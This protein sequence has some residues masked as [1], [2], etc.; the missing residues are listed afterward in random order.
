[1]GFFVREFKSVSGES[2]AVLV[3]DQGSPFFWSNV[4]AVSDYRN[5]G[6]SPRTISKLL[7]TLAM[8][9]TWADSYGI[10]FD[11]ALSVGELITM[12]QAESLAQ[13]LRLNA[14]NQEIAVSK[15][16]YSFARNKVITLERQQG[17]RKTE[18]SEVVA[19][20]AFEAATRIRWVIKYIEWQMDRRLGSLDR[21]GK[22]SSLIKSVGAIVVSRL[23]ALTPRAKQTSVDEE[24]LEGISKEECVIAEELFRPRSE[25]NPFTPGFHQERNYL[26]W[27][28]LY[29]TGMR[30]EEL[31]A[32]LVEKVDYSLRRVQITKSKT[33]KRTVPISELLAL[34][35]HDFILNHWSKISPRLRKHGFLFTTEKGDHLGLNSINLIFRT[36]RRNNDDLPDFLAPHVMRRTW[37]DRFLELDDI[38]QEQSGNFVG[39]QAIQNRLQG[40]GDN[41]K[42]RERYGKGVIRKK[43]DKIAEK[44][45]NEL[46]EKKNDQE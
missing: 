20:S 22:D 44:L 15:T 21:A 30:R 11:K 9:H 27:R 1:M 4:F 10:D 12:E 18:G 45:A 14:E 35:F 25:S 36:A 42:M 5:T 26:I 33:L 3:N 19:V 7:R 41:S 40:W 23:K 29:E 24:R 31:Q 17:Y 37:N 43:A 39:G 38:K 6:R 2:V 28:F 32:I 16:S 46:T 34:K 8:A 13:F